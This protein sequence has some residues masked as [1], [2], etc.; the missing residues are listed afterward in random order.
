MA[1]LAPICEENKLFAVFPYWLLETKPIQDLAT[2]SEN[3]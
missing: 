2:V 3:P 1:L